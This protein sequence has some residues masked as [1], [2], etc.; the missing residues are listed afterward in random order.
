MAEIK[1]IKLS[2]N[3]FDD[4]K[5]KLIRT[6]PEGDSIIIIWVQILCLAGKINDSGLVYMGQNLAYTDEMLATILGHPLNVMRIALQTLEQFGMIEVNE[7]GTIDVLNWE[8]HQSTDKMARIREQNR[9]RKRKYDLREKLRKIGHDPDEKHVPDDLE[10]LEK[11]VMDIEKS[12]DT[13]TLPNV[14]TKNINVTKNEESLNDGDNNCNVTVTSGNATEVRSK[15]LD[16]RGKKKEVRSKQQEVNSNQEENS[17]DESPTTNN[18]FT[19]F[20]KLWLFPNLTQREILQEFVNLHGDD[21]V[22]AAIKIAGSKDV[23]KTRAIP[24]V[25]AV[26]QEWADGNVKTL[27]QARTYEKNRNQVNKK[28]NFNNKKVRKKETLPDWADS[29]T[30]KDDELVSEEEQERFRKR[31]KESMKMREENER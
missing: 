6:M 21:L 17:G 20:E 31:L 4:E 27:E 2:V 29:D 9:L 25:E 24:F 11:Y 23:K 19:D 12:Y 1:W 16:V 10:E 22:S 7:D 26:L 5:I 30:S 18:A 14:T 13:V 3:M 8:K 28:S 15:K